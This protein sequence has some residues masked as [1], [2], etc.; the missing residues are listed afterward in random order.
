MIVEKKNIIEDFVKKIS[1]SL[2]YSFLYTGKINQR[3]SKIVSSNV[4]DFPP[5]I[6]VNLFLWKM[7]K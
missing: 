1:N 2:L 5:S 4:I 3:F 6:Q 7:I